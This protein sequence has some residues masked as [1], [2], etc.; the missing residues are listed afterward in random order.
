MN[1]EL[2]CYNNFINYALNVEEDEFI[3][4]FYNE[5]YSY[6]TIS[7]LEM[8]RNNFANFWSSLDIN[9]KNKYIELVKKKYNK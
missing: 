5:E 7:R 9:N 8:M 1:E 3:K 6:Y 2:L 4:D